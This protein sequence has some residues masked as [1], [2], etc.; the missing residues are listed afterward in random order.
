M[1]VRVRPEEHPN[2]YNS[3]KDRGKAGIDSAVAPGRDGSLAYME[4]S[5][6]T[7]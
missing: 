6:Q 2:V 4:N 7:L 1:H 3:L 5:S